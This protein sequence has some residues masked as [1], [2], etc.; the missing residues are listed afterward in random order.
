LVYE[1]ASNPPEDWAVIKVRADEAPTIS[2]E[3]L[4]RER[5]TMAPALYSQEYE[6]VFT[7]AGGG[8]FDM[9]IYDRLFRDRE[10]V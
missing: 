8:I 9:E 10:P 4:E 7:V 6:G 2:A 3:F 1:L 5:A